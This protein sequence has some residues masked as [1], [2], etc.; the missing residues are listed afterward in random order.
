LSFK[1]RLLAFDGPFCHLAVIDD[2]NKGES[3][4]GGRKGQG[5]PMHQETS[6]SYF[7]VCNKN[8]TQKST[9]LRLDIIVM[10]TWAILTTEEN[11]AFFSDV[12]PCSCV[13]IFAAFLSNLLLSFS[14]VNKNIC[15]IV[16]TEAANSSEIMADLL[17]TTRRHIAQHSILAI[18]TGT[19]NPAY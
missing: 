13:E 6:N 14:T 2:S 9:L 7:R 11:T 12:T 17:S 3:Y 16:R 1:Y 10:E 4:G 5:P 15:S 19:S 8:D 18:S